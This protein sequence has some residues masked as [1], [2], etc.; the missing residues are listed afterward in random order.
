VLH[1]GKAACGTRYPL[2][3]KGDAD[4]AIRRVGVLREVAGNVSREDHVPVKFDFHSQRAE[5]RYG[6]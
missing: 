1:Q 2:G 3:R 4:F 6:D 5:H